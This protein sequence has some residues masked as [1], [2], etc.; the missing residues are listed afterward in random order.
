MW[1]LKEVPAVFNQYHF[2][3]NPD[4][5]DKMHKMFSANG[6]SQ[7]RRKRPPA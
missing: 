5:D 3:I 1:E 4:F 7:G 6:P 2:T